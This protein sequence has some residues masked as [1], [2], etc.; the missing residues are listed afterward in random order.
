MKRLKVLA[1]MSGG[2]DSAVAAALL[3]EQ[4]HEVTGVTLKLWCYGKS[5][6][7]PRACC[8]LDAIDDARGVART[9][10]FPHHVVQAEEI[11]RALVLQPFFDVYAGGRTPYPCSLCNQH[12][13]S[14][15]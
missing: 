10:G 3:A 15:F 8:T 6:L 2:V 13:T 12:L 14:F 11:F 4:G 1:A 5:P 9:M 7:S